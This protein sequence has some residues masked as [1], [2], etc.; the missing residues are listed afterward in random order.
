MGAIVISKFFVADPNGNLGDFRSR[1]IGGAS[2]HRFTFQV[3]LEAK[4]VVSAEL[5][6]V[7]QVG[8][9]GVNK[10][11]DIYSDYASEGEVYNIHSES[12]TTTLYDLIGLTDKI[13]SLDLMSILSELASGDFVGIFVDHKTIGGTIDYLGIELK[14]TC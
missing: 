8:A 7:V 9:D 3:P 1:G 5:K 6:G 11:I 2:G 13:W 10:D 14:Y 4:M 12:D